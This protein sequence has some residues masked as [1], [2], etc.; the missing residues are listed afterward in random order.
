[1][2]DAL[3]AAEVDEQPASD[4]GAGLV[5]AMLAAAG[6]ELIVEHVHDPL[7]RPVQAAWALLRDGTAA[8]EMAAASGLVLLASHEL[9]PL[10]ATTFGTGEL[11][12]AVLARGCRRIIVGVGGSATVD[13]G[14]GAMQALGAR[15]RDAHGAE[16]P[17]GGAALARLATIE[18]A[19]VRPDL[20][21]AE[22]VV[23]S[24]VTNV[25]CGPEGAARVFGP[26]KGASA[27][28][29]KALD[30][31]LA[32]FAEVVRAEAGIDVQTLPGSGAAGGL[33]AGLVVAAGARIVPGFSIVAEATRLE[34]RI[35][36]ADIIITGEGKLDAQTPY[37]KTAAG[38]ARLARL[39]GKPVGAIAGTV[40]PGFDADD[41]FDATVEA[42]R[43]G[44][45]TEEAMRS[46][47]DLVMAAAQGLAALLAA[48]AYSDRR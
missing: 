25:L 7:M 1:V 18:L 26:Q 20:T 5:D 21:G 14:A 23:A 48:A 38:V 42:R 40:G 24:D 9:D 28:D 16:L 47:R 45:S 3:P 31:A 4:G 44:M 33:G 37:G 46:A 41:L 6:G 29:V 27:E 34:E 11:I 35:A 19:G 32:R 10:H 8:I 13:A 2:R 30:A 36:A 12:A 39:H 15:L 22:V 17:R 43:E